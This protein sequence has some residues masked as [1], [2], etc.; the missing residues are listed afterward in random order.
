MNTDEETIFNLIAKHRDEYSALMLLAFKEGL[1]SVSNAV[2]SKK[3]IGTYYDFPT[4]SYSDNGLPSLSS[5][6]L[7]GPIEY[8]GCFGALGREPL[9]NEDQLETFNNLVIFVKQHSDLHERF[10]PENYNTKKESLNIDIGAIQIKSSIKDAIE[11]Y[12]HLNNSFEYEETKAI[13]IIKPFVSYVFNEKLDIDIVIPLLFLD[14]DTDDY[15]ISENVFLQRIKDKYHLSR[16]KLGPYNVSANQYV[17]SSATHALVLKG[18]HVPNQKHMWNFDILSKPSAYPLD[19]IETFFGALRIGTDIDTGYAQI[20]S[21]ARGWC[22]HAKANLPYIQGTTVRA[23]P[24]WFENYYWNIDVVP[25]LSKDT[26]DKLRSIFNQLINAKENSINLA[27]KRLNR[28]LVR[29]SEEDSV[30]D[31]TIALEALLS[32]DGN[33]EMTHKLAMRVGAITKLS[34]DFKKTPQ[35]AF[36]DIKSIYAYRSAIVHG[37]KSLDKKRMIKIDENEKVT[38]HS[39]AIDYLR[40]LLKVLLENADYR[41]PKKIDSDLLL[42]SNNE[43]A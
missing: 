16:Y 11:R 20:F 9:I 38:A 7:N 8:K 3:Y 29:D 18:W 37:S 36:K 2:A 6:L 21:V 31:A 15:E 23:Y 24:S 40:V 1:A 41:E 43:K 10:I 17:A 4:L 12:I 26:I 13:S 32:D 27:I 28:C 35:Q 25:K 19:F 33:Q 14:F 22:A 39:L 30:L 34:K 42:G 5:S